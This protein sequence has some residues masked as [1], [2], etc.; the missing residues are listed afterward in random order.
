M[1][2]IKNKRFFDIN[3]T[4]LK[5]AGLWIPDQGESIPL[6]IW[7][8][9]YNVIINGFALLF[10]MP[11][12]FVAFQDSK[13]VLDDAI[14][15]ASVAVTHLLALIKCYVWLNSRKDILSMI[16]EL[17]QKATEYDEIDDFKPKVMVETEK[18]TKNFTLTVFFSL[19]A[20]V[21]ITA[22]SGSM[23]I[24]LTD[25]ERYEVFNVDAN[26]VTTYRYTQKL[27]Y[28]AWMPFDTQASKLNFCI[29]VVYVCYPALTQAWTISGKAINSC[30]V[31]A[32]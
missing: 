10:F 4:L 30:P 6:Q 19:C 26:N 29:G 1:T 21:S 12:E 3:I 11:C 17:E 16:A 32:R 24:L 9:I 15:N 5:L 25:H 28:W 27:P 7:Y 13:Y 14:K 18:S 20:S 8:W 22:F 31:V 2:F 23:A